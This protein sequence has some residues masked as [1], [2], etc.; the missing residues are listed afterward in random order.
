VATAE[1]TDRLLLRLP[2]VAALLG[3]GRSTVYELVQR[4]DLPTV[5]VGRALRIPSAALRD[6]V[7]QQTTEA[8][9]ES[10]P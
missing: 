6:W 9:N 4:G 5:H 3:I 7:E 8:K 10:Q 1:L 2:E